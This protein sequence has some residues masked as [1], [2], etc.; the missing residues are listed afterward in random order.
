MFRV[1]GG[2][3]HRYFSDEE[4]IVLLLLLAA[5]LVV[6]LLFG[7]MLAP[8]FAGLVLAFVLQGGVTW[9]ER[10]KCPHILA[11]SLTFAC[12]IAVLLA[13]MLLMMPLIW[14]QSTAL[15]NELPRMVQQWRQML[16]HLPETYPGFVSEAQ[17][18]AWSE[19]ASTQLSRMGQWLVSFSLS[20]LPNLV[21][22]LIY[23]VLVPI[24]VFFFL[25]DRMML[26]KWF[27]SKLP[28]ERRMIDQV[29]EEMS[30]QIANY[31]R[32]KFIEI[33]IV[34]VTTFIAFAFMELNYA[35]LLALLVGL[36]VVIP[37]VGA[38]VVTIPVAAIG[39][40]QWG[41]EHQ[42]FVLMAVY[43]V[44][45][46]LDGNVLVPLLF[47]E[48]VNLHP[49]AIIIAVL[50]FGGL[51]GFWGVFFAIPLATLVKAVFS[52][53]PTVGQVGTA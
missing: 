44:I 5:A 48:A 52:A 8:V 22:I 13:V 45:Q 50:M 39:L 43:G 36:S 38:A 24:L 26:V 10:L 42:F 12:F 53:W 35:A 7:T 19:A 18:N 47:S 14:E 40:F 51:W 30:L 32:G 34:G 9:L 46:A 1:I 25:K 23:L 33:V 20:K 17:V 2:W 37:Y 15:L 4:A 27:S 11:V 41:F 16:Q 31:I 21:G 49:I 6:I 3:V 29:S 28:R